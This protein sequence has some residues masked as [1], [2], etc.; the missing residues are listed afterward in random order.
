VSDVPEGDLLYVRASPSPKS[1]PLTGYPNK[2]PLS[3]TGRCNGLHLNTTAGQPH[4]RQREA[5]RNTWCEVW[6][7][8]TGNG[9]FRAGW[10]YGRYI[11]PL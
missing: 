7:D 6:L 1:R 9:R 4:W 2:T 8:P 5:V 11:R 10:V 3:L